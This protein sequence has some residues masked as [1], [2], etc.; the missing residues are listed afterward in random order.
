[1]I[2]KSLPILAFTAFDELSRSVLQSSEDIDTVGESLSAVSDIAARVALGDISALVQLP[3]RISEVNAAQDAAALRDRLSRRDEAIDFRTRTGI[4]ENN[5]ATL[6]RAL[7][8]PIGR[9]DPSEAPHTIQ[10]LQS[11]NDF[12]GTGLDTLFRNLSTGRNDIAGGLTAGIEEALENSNLQE[13]I[14]RSMTVLAVNLERVIYEPRHSGH[15][16]TEYSS[17][18]RGCRSSRIQSAIRQTNG[19]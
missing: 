1:M 11:L 6:A 2:L 19:W 7:G 9:L 5:L 3:F 17:F 13:S 16:S 10:G 14:A 8:I 18:E 4:A 12:S 15:L